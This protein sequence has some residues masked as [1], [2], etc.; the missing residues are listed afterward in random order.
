VQLSHVIIVGAGPAGLN[1]ALVLG[2]C[3]R[4]VLLFDD[5]K[6]RNAVSRALHGFLSRDG[7]H[8]AELRRIARTQLEPYESVTLLEA[9]VVEAARTGYGFEVQTSAGDTFHGRKLLL[10][11]GVVDELPKIAGF[12]DLYGVAAFHCPYCDG[13][14]VRDRPLAVYG[15][16]DRKGGGLALE[17]TLWSKDVVLCTDGPSGLSQ[18]YRRRL[19]NHNVLIREERIIL[20]QPGSPSGTEAS[21][22]IVFEHGPMLSSRVLFFNT[23]RRQ[24]TDLARRLGSET[25]ETDGCKM[26]GQFEAAGV[27]GLYVAGDASRDVLQV[28][29]AAAEG[30]QAAIAINT[31]LLGEDL[32]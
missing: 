11:A 6:P 27:H 30:V 32:G 1:A 21:L 26:N 31:A 3:R 2:R 12:D 15:K 8:P 24:A 25:Y 17:M 4:K 22:D 29:V 9:T 19:M 14:E 16:G 13:W 23:G 28:I 10:A 7:I 20:L 5:G 18:E